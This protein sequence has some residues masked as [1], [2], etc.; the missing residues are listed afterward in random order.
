MIGKQCYLVGDP[1]DTLTGSTDTLTGYTTPL[2]PPACGAQPVVH[3]SPAQ[4]HV[5][6]EGRLKIGVRRRQEIGEGRE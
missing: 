2:H 1:G 3:V 6:Q 5:E 4:S